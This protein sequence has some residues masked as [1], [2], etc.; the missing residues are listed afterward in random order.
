MGEDG[1]KQTGASGYKKGDKVENE[2]VDIAKKYSRE[3]TYSRGCKREGMIFGFVYFVYDKR[4]TPTC[5]THH[6]HRRLFSPPSLLTTAPTTLMPPNGDGATLQNIH[7]CHPP[8]NCLL[9]LS[10]Y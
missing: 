2:E 1:G 6:S 8:Y 5:V 4:G 9:P 10:T 3:K 7:P